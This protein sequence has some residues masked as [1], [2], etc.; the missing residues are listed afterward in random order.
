MQNKFQ[1]NSDQVQQLDA[2]MHIFRKCVAGWIRETGGCWRT[3][4][5]Y[6]TCSL[7]HSF[8]ECN[9]LMKLTAALTSRFHIVPQSFAGH[10]ECEW[11]VGCISLL[12]RGW[13]GAC[14][15]FTCSRWSL[16][17]VES[18]SNDRVKWSD[19][20]E[21]ECSDLTPQRIRRSINCFRYAITCNDSIGA[22]LA[23]A[24]ALSMR[25]MIHTNPRTLVW[26]HTWL[27]FTSR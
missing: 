3:Y 6:S 1:P 4:L 22:P 27:R 25:S 11:L 24:S 23:L 9:S 5:M 14:C 2:G 18:M 7:T 19:S 16:R 21:N 15:G 10:L 17:C 20:G 26:A 8:C 13:R 12:T